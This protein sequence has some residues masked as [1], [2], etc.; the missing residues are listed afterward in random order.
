MLRRPTF[1]HP[2]RRSNSFKIN[3]HWRVSKNLH[4]KEH[5]IFRFRGIKCS[6]SKLI[7]NNVLFKI[8]F[9]VLTICA[10]LFLTYMG[11]NFHITLCMPNARL[12]LNF[13]FFYFERLGKNVFAETILP[14]QIKKTNQIVWWHAKETSNRV[15]GGIGEC[16][17]TKTRT[18]KVGNFD[19]NERNF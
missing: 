14:R 4:E 11:I 19:I 1:P 6:I 12:Y 8:T 10:N 13:N 2:K 7:Y 16:S 3:D 5:E 17:C 15:V 18:I 9:W